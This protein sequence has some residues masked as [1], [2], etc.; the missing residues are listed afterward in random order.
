MTEYWSRAE[1]DK[2]KCGEGGRRLLG[3]AKRG[4]EKAYN[5]EKERG[6]L[7]E[8][9]EEGYLAADASFLYFCLL[10]D[11]RALCLGESLGVKIRGND[12]LLDLLANAVVLLCYHRYGILAFFTMNPPPSPE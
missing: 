9:E 1:A 2:K 6:G 10:R 8:E 7:E 11:V 12:K 5:E 4:W 3:G